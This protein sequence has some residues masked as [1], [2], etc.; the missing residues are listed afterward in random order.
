MS[1]FVYMLTNRPDGTLYVGITN[2]LIRRVYE[3]KSKAVQGFS[4]RYNLDQLGYYEIH[5]T[6]LNAIQREKNIKHWP[7]QWKINLIEDT[8]PDW[9]D[10]YDEVTQ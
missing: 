6:A 3:H 1:Y 10:L 2:N 4:K 5:D 9:R 7:R 8:N